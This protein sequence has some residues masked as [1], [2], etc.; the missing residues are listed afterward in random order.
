MPKPLIAGTGRRDFQTPGMTVEV[1]T[2][3][4]TG[5]P[6]MR[7]SKTIFSY[8]FREQVVP[9]FVCL[10]GLILVLIIGRLT[11]LTRLLFTSSLTLTD[12]AEIIALL[13]PTIALY[14]LPMAT[15]IGVLLA[16]VRLGS[17]NELV[18]L[19][20]AGIGFKQFFA[21]V[22][23]VVLITT[24]LSFAVSLYALPLANRALRHKLKSLGRA[25][26]PSLLHE[27]T[28][29]DTVPGVILFF[30]RVDPV[31]LALHGIFIQ[32]S[33]KEKVKASIVA[34]NARLIDLSDKNQLVL[35][36]NN[37][38]ITRVGKRYDDAQAIFFDTYDLAIPLDELLPSAGHKSRKRNEMTLGELSEK[39]RTKHDPR[40][41]MEYHQR[42]ALP[43]ACLLLGC[44]AA[45]L[46]TLFQ[47]GN[48]MMGVI[49][50]I[51]IFLGYY[52][53]LSA[54]KGLGEN[55]LIPPA[56]AI[57]TPNAVCTVLAGYLWVKT[58]RE[59]PFF[60]SRLAER[61]RRQPPPQPPTPC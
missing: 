38:V 20:C 32:D 41:A 23:A 17:D 26:I 54:G 16:F 21:P 15:L 7:I 13:L 56:V 48:R 4:P 24:T 55:G 36:I 58:N 31:H 43:M 45:P 39:Y 25:V 53:L 51:A 9:L 22:S 37:G 1:Q 33:R 42:L 8:L 61:N 14:A 50:G 27:G 57:W 40:L 28:F 30:N 19:R 3:T 2:E 5:P 35:K 6:P 46:G 49:T 52:I 18:A 10:G 60:W 12:I 47:R 11:Q 34:A 44:V 59:S 29:I